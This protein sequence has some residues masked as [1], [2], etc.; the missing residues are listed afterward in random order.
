MIGSGRGAR[1]LLLTGV[2]VEKLLRAKLA[3][4]KLRYDPLQNF[5][6]IF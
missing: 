6:L 3:K 1:Q 2:A 5:L 4:T